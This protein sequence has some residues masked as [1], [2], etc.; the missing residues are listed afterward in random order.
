MSVATANYG[1][2][3]RWAGKGLSP[4]KLFIFGKMRLP[5]V[6]FELRVEMFFQRKAHAKIGDELPLRGNIESAANLLRIEDRHPANAKIFR[7][8][9]KPKSVDRRDHRI[10][11]GLWHGLPAEAKTRLRRTVAEHGEMNRRLAQPR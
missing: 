10:I 8:C 5:M 3:F 1:I 4:V 2:K 11:Q 9:T 7:P 6:T